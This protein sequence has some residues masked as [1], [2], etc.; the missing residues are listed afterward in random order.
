MIVITS[1]SR[2]HMEH[3]GCVLSTMLFN[4]LFAEILIVALKQSGVDAYILVD[5]AYL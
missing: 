4:V 5:L 3:Q 1:G 2:W